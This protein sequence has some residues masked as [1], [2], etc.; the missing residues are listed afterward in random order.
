MFPFE[1]YDLQTAYMAKVIDCLENSTNAVLESPTGTGKTL[2]LLCSSLAWITVQ[3]LKVPNTSFKNTVPTLTS[4]PI[5]NSQND[6]LKLQLS[7]AERELMEKGIIQSEKFA[8]V[9]KIIY[10]TR[11]HSQIAQAM[12]ELKTSDYRHIK[13][14]VVGSRDQLCI[15]PDVLKETSNSNKIHMCKLKITTRSCSFYYR[16]EKQKDDVLLRNTPVLD[17]EDLVA[18]GRKAKCCPYFLSKEM[19]DDADIV[20]MPYN[21]LLDPKARKASNVQLTNTIIILDEAHNVEKMCEDSAS[22]QI[23]SSEVAVCIEEVTHVRDAR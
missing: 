14:A 13:A 22:M 12:G 10:A 15:H 18:F 9:P 6:K 20:F 11:T 16:V 19:I 1:P 4:F 23:A 3:K 17:I 21:Y 7:D 5:I 2:S 8:K